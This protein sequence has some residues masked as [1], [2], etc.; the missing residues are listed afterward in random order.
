MLHFV[1][2]E[3]RYIVR[4]I[5][6]TLP[7]EEEFFRA[8]VCF[9]TQIVVMD[10]PPGLYEVPEHGPLPLH[11]RGLVPLTR[12]ADLVGLHL[13]G[14]GGRLDLKIKHPE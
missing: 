4:R 12:H 3:W 1:V 14:G 10:A 2:D 9:L 8:A 11:G 6:P 5:Y 7:F 13:Q